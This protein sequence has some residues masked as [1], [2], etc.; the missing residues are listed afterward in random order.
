MNTLVDKQRCYFC[1]VNEPFNV[2]KDNKKYR[3]LIEIHH[4]KEK[5]EGG[6]NTDENLVPVCSNC[7]SKIHLG[8]INPKKWFFTTGGWKLQWVD[9]KGIE[10]Y[11]KIDITI[12]RM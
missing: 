4:I 2:I 12:N 5:N 6:T 8:L 1:G 9:D 10:H 11:G 7:H 3:K